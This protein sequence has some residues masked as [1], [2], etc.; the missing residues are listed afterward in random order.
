[1]ALPEAFEASAQQCHL[2]RLQ[3]ESE[4]DAFL[5]A[6]A[7]Q[8]SPFVSSDRLAQ[9]LQEI[10]CREEILR[11]DII[12]TPGLRLPV[13]M[14][15]DAVAVPI[16][17]ICRPRDDDLQEWLL[18]SAR[19]LLAQARLAGALAAFGVAP[20]VAQGA[21]S[22]LVIAASALILDARS[23]DLLVARLARLCRGEEWIDSAQF[24][25]VAGWRNEEALRTAAE[26]DPVRSPLAANCRLS[27]E[28]LRGKSLNLR[29]APSPPGLLC[30][31]WRRASLA[32]L[33]CFLVRGLSSSRAM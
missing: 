25:D 17:Q 13:Q 7:L 27:V 26:A 33:S 20:P 1:M 4:P 12:L 6:A 18:A 10:V 28:R 5:V 29:R 31:L 2:W 11:T 30:R 14:V 9:V 21:P 15:R 24:A 16:L 32:P 8:I 3:P 22:E 19:G 23:L